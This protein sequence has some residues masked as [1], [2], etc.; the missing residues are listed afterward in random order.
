[1]NGK[2]RLCM[3]LESGS[4]CKER[5]NQRH[6]CIFFLLPLPTNCLSLKLCVEFVMVSVSGKITLLTPALLSVMVCVPVIDA[7][8]RL[9]GVSQG[10]V[11]FWDPV[12]LGFLHTG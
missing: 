8:W 5:R 9:G 4:L 11:L 1:M 12:G 6:L 3:S 7:G 2:I 10:E